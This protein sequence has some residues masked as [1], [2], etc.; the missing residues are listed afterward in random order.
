MGT[1][2]M[3]WTTLSV[4]PTLLVAR[5]C[6]SRAVNSRMAKV[7]LRNSFESGEVRPRKVRLYWEKRACSSLALALTWE[8]FLFAR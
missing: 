5:N 6:R 8:R 3:A 1:L 4:R 2:F 7:K